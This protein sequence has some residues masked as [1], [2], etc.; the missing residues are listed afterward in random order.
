MLALPRIAYLQGGFKCLTEEVSNEQIIINQ[1]AFATVA[2]GVTT[3]YEIPINITI[4]NE[5]DGT[6][7]NHYQ[8]YQLERAQVAIDEMNSFFT[9]GMKFYLCNITFVNNSLYT[10]NY[11]QA[12]FRNIV[13]PIYNDPNAVNIYVVKDLAG[14]SFAGYTV[15]V[16]DNSSNPSQIGCILSSPINSDILAHE[17]GHLFGLAHTFRFS[18]ICPPIVSGNSC[19]PQLLPDHTYNLHA[20]SD[21]TGCFCC[22]GCL[23]SS[24]GGTIYF[25]CNTCNLTCDCTDCSIWGDGICDTPVD[26]GITVCPSANCEVVFTSE[27]TGQPITLQYTPDYN[28]IM[29]YYLAKNRFSNQ[30][31]QVM[32]MRLLEYG[33]F[34]LTGESECAIF[35]AEEL[36]AR[37]GYVYR[38]IIE[39]GSYAFEPI[40]Q[41]VLKTYEVNNT[42]FDSES[43]TSTTGRYGVRSDVMYILEDKSVGI[44]QGNI[45]GPLDRRNRFMFGINYEVT[46]RDIIRIRR[47]V[48]N[49]ELLLKPYAWIASDVNNSGSITNQ[50]I[51]LIQQS[52]L[53]NSIFYQ[54]V[55]CFRLFPKYYLDNQWGFSVDFNSSPF[56]ATWQAPVG[57]T[58]RSYQGNTNTPSYLSD[59]H[60]D[61]LNP[62][63]TEED[64]WTFYAIKSGDATMDPDEQELFQG[65]VTS[66]I[67]NQ[68]PVTVATNRYI[69]ISV[70]AS[71]NKPNLA[72]YQMAL[73]F[74]TTKLSLI[75]IHAGDIP[76]SLNDYFE[77]KSTGQLRTVWLHPSEGYSVSQGMVTLFRITM[78]AKSYLPNVFD[79]IELNETS[80][81]SG[82]FTYG[83]DP[84]TADITLEAISTGRQHFLQEVFPNP[85]SN[86]ISFKFNLAYSGVVNITL[87]DAFGPVGQ[88]QG[89]YPQGEN[90][91]TFTNLSPLSTGTISYQVVLAGEYNSGIIIKQ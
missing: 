67:S 2:G 77:D 45:N 31:E 50:D 37:D 17:I 36:L 51:I 32:L 47:H 69:E 52:I 21:Q 84:I 23:S 12:D 86:D 66:N 25:P 24:S 73:E 59:M 14:E 4:F 42:D 60:I 85:F 16:I 76:F 57:Q 27:I 78:E 39:E 65:F 34:L 72:G 28:N 5:S 13:F 54:N 49:T 71:L 19:L 70:K 41:F 56:A 90:V 15:G 3:E 7:I 26:P 81:A 83:L 61:L 43:V 22:Q 1:H 63:V 80:L 55:P 35:P 40:S 11:P 88:Y 6:P 18:A 89:I 58:P 74:D 82:F 79:Y 8:Y 29:S 9:N 46:T 75:G 91:H 38:P 68:S 64:T 10:N 48:L 62:D 20:D 53:G 30:Q 44:G 33:Q 87:L